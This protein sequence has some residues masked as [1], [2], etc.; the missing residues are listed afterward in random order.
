ML[1]R[2]E[3]RTES[4][5]SNLIKMR[6]NC[7]LLIHSGPS[8]I[9]LSPTSLFTLYRI[10]ALDP[11]VQP[12]FD[13]HPPIHHFLFCC[14]PNSVPSFV[15]SSNLYVLLRILIALHSAYLFV[16]PSVPNSFPLSVILINCVHPLVHSC[17]RL[18]FVHSSVRF[19]LWF[20]LSLIRSLDPNSHLF[21][22]PNYTLTWNNLWNKNTTKWLI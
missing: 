16:R 20:T 19:F 4:P 21:I 14:Q 11:P 2:S 1:L 3:N 9:S 15:H 18:S 13:D 8:F 12:P 17:V 7:S 10:Q 6:T 5:S 22:H